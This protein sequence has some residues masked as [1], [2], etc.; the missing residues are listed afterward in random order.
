[1]VDRYIPRYSIEIHEG[2]KNIGKKHH[3]ELERGNR[4]H[5]PKANQI[6]LSS[7]VFMTDPQCSQDSEPVSCLMRELLLWYMHQQ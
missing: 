4:S 6:K 2:V 7:T 5:L 3:N 1:M